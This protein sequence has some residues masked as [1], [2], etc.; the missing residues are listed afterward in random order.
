MLPLQE[1]APE[2]ETLKLGALGEASA[3]VERG[4]KVGRAIVEFA[5]EVVFAGEGA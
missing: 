2:T 1:T 5:E 4:S 3:F